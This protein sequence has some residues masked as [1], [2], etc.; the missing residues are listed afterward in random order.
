MDYTRLTKDE[1]AYELRVRGVT[2]LTNGE[3]MK[4]ALAQMLRLEKDGLSSLLDRVTE[5]ITEELG[6][7]KTKLE[8]L[9]TAINARATGTVASSDKRRWETRLNHVFRRL[10]RLHVNEPELT[11]ARSGMIRETVAMLTELKPV[12]S[13][14]AGAEREAEEDDSEE[15]SRRSVEDDKEPE[16]LHRRTLS[17]RSL[18]S[19]SDVQ[20]KIIIKKE[21][22]PVWKWGIT[23]S[24]DGQGYSV[25]AFLERVE[26]LRECRRVS[27]EELWLSAIDLF[28]GPALIWFRA[29]RRQ[30][31]S[32]E[33]L[34]KFLRQEF[35]PLDYEEL[36]WEEIKSRTQG[37][38]ERLTVF[39]SIMM[40]LFSRLS[41]PPAE[42]KKLAIIRR[43]LLPYYTDRLALHPVNSLTELF[44]LTRKIE[45]SRVRIE[46]FKPP[47]SRRAC[48]EVDLAYQGRLKNC[49]TI[50]VESDDGPTGTANKF[51]GEGSCWNCG[52]PTHFFKNCPSKRKV[53][54]VGCGCN[55]VY[56]RECSSC[57]T[58]APKN[59][60]TRRD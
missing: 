50:N 48:L 21:Q 4:K 45:E 54:C 57:N 55:G 16:H 23:F 42:D 17:G 9:K 52:E 46:K 27:K 35:L 13:E 3:E 40:N 49:A 34:A 51:K 25:N 28:S 12:S 24:G 22:V 33:E 6:T 53:F 38:D 18:A 2:D 20:T 56:R 60:P 19:T 15:E 8:E 37:S 36:L 29:V 44:D 26:E 31:E 41:N 59:S 7:C 11:D 30:L 39:I 32:W 14:N 10:G 5:G 43:N 1:L 58:P 47:P